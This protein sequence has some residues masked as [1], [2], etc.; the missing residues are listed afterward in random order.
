MK[1]DVG[2]LWLANQVV[3]IQHNFSIQWNAVLLPESNNKYN[4]KF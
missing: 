1:F 3:Q 4:F 2:V